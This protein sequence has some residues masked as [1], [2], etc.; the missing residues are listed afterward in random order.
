M[1]GTVTGEALL[2]LQI[3]DERPDFMVADL[4]CICASP[5]GSEEVLKVTDAVGDDGNGTDT[6]SLGGSTKLITMK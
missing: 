6:L 3:E 5:L 2:L 4:G 1:V